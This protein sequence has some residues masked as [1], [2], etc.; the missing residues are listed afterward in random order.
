MAVQRGSVHGG[1]R[2]GRD[3]AARPAAPPQWNPAAARRAGYTAAPLPEE[4]DAE[5]H[6]PLALVRR[7][8]AGDRWAA[9]AGARLVEVREGYARDDD[10]A[11][12]TST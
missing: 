12:A 6:D 4:P 8:M 10:A 7:V 1:L 5:D 2:R 11:A 3:D 9:A